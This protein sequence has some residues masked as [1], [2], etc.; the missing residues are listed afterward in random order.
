M[1]QTAILAKA[2]GDFLRRS[3]TVVYCN[4]CQSAR[5]DGPEFCPKCGAKLVALSTIKTKSVSAPAVI[6]ASTPTVSSDLPDAV[7]VEYEGVRNGRFTTLGKPRAQCVRVR[8]KNVELSPRQWAKRTGLNLNTI[9]YRI[10]AGYTPEQIFTPKSFRRDQNYQLR[11]ASTVKPV[12]L[13]PLPAVQSE[14]TV[15]KG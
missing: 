14:T 9:N 10:A 1:G 11:V 8:Y 4:Y 2:V 12:E 7:I 15:E 5:L 3:S 6:K 13:Q